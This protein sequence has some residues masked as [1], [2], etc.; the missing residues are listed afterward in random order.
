MYPRLWA[1]ERLNTLA[2][3]MQAVQAGTGHMK[4]QDWTKL[5]DSI[6]RQARGP[7]ARPATE[8]AREQGDRISAAMGFV[9][10]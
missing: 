5:V 7:Q 8:S 9:R 2:L 4:Q 10:A 3:T 1:E 6:E